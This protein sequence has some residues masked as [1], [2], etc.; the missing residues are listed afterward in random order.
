[1]SNCVLVHDWACGVLVVVQ[2]EL[3]RSRIKGEL[4]CLVLPPVFCE[5]SAASG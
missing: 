1:M 4:Q 2:A 5:D 3:Q